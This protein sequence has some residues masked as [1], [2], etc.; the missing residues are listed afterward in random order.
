MRRNL[1]PLHVA[2]SHAYIC[3][4]ATATH[5]CAA[6]AKDNLAAKVSV[7]SAYVKLGRG[8]QE[9]GEVVVRASRAT[10]EAA[11]QLLRQRG[12]CY[13]A[14]MSVVICSSLSGGCTV[15]TDVQTSLMRQSV[16]TRCLARTP[17]PRLAENL[18]HETLIL[19]GRGEAL[20]RSAPHGGQASV[21]V[22]SAAGMVVSVQPAQ[23]HHASRHSS[24]YVL[25]VVVTGLWLDFGLASVVSPRMPVARFCPGH[26]DGVRDDRAPSA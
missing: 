20:Q 3:A 4:A 17:M 6:S 26:S 12:S 19:C 22:C 14:P 16:M 9:Q 5:S 11:G 15:A 8:G 10:F 18:A 21:T 1:M 23:P 25:L 13:Q 24:C 2:S 7:G